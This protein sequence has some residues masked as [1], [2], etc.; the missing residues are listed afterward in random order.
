MVLEFLI[1]CLS[2]VHSWSCSHTSS[3]GVPGAY[4]EQASLVAYP[5]C[6]PAPYAQFE[7]A[8]EV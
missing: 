2:C 3:K 7:N 1:R 8:F 6:T 4:S 5:G